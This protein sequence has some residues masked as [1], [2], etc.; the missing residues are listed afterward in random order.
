MCR[1]RRRG[2]RGRRRRRRRR[3]MALRR[4]KQSQMGTVTWIDFQTNGGALRSDVQSAV[5]VVDLT[6][7]VAN[8]RGKEQIRRQAG[9]AGT[10]VSWPWE[11]ALE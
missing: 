11:A 2:R 4:P 8:T 5:T 3:I 10:G 9:M 7:P 1:R 6:L